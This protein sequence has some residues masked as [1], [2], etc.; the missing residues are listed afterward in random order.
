MRENHGIRAPMLM[1]SR[2]NRPWV[3]MVKASK[4]WRNEQGTK[5]DFV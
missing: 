2:Q 3:N 1:E 4:R 5:L